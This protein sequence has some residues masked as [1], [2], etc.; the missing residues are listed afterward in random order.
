MMANESLQHNT[1]S[2]EK[3]LSNRLL[4]VLS[5]R[6]KT[7]LKVDEFDRFIKELDDDITSNLALKNTRK[8]WRT[9]ASIYSKRFYTMTHSS[10]G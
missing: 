7:T 10:V 1:V 3:F 5:N 2:L 6:T 4:N 9:S 8:L